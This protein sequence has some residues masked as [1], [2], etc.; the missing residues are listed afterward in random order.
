[1]SSGLIIKAQS[2]FFTVHTDEGPIISKLR[3]RLKKEK[4][5]ADLATVGDHVTVTRLPDGTGV[6]EEVEERVRALK[7]RKPSPKGR[8]QRASDDDER[9]AV[10]LAN[11]DQAVLVFACAQPSPSLGMLDRFLVVA[12]ANEVPAIICANKIDLIGEEEARSLFGIYEKLGYRVFH[13]STRTGQGVEALRAQLIGRISAL[14]GPS[15]VGKSSLLN[16]IQ[17]G[18]GI[19]VKTVSQATNKGRHTTVHP[20][21]VPLTG[22]GWVADTPGIRALALHDIEPYEVDGYFP[23]IQPYIHQCAFSNCT[24][25]VETGCAVRAA[26][27]R[28]EIDKRRYG[29]YVRIR[30]GQAA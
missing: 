12:E 8:G 24:H 13:T 9:E 23:D 25:V 16:A 22:G 30:A 1:M 27:E 3:G 2:G 18:L 21:L 11:P 20:E 19:D 26:V 28:G 17:P 7:R 29:S 6:I 5:F 10:I 14:T 15:G 4:T